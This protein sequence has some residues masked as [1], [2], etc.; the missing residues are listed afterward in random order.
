MTD[1]KDIRFTEKKVDESWK[2]KI[3]DKIDSGPS[4]AGEIP[5]K[6]SSSGTKSQS[7]QTSQPN[8]TSKPFINLITSLGYQAM[9]HI[10]EMEHP[11]T[12]QKEVNLDAAKEVID[13]LVALRAKADGNMSA[14]EKG[15]LETIVPELQMKYSGQV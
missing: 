11:E 13:L 5:P 7:S 9:I 15:L 1:K 10:G 6:D 12:K 8:E 3:S 14:E 2:D 4:T